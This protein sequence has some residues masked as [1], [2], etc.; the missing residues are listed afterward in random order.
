[1]DHLF[2]DNSGFGMLD[3]NGTESH[4]EF[5][6]YCAGIVEEQTDDYLDPM[7]AGDI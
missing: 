2:H 7:L 5:I 1:M 6:V 4:Q 3:R